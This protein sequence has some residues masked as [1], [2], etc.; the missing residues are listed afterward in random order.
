MSHLDNVLFAPH[1]IA[2]TDELFRDI[3]RTVCQGMVD[4]ASGKRPNGVVNPEVFEQPA[5]QEKW[6]RVQS[7]SKS[8]V[9]V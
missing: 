8:A 6:T 7:Q 3:G 4:L 9:G 2:W 5:F 1:C